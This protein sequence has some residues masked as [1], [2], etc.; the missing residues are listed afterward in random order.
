MKRVE[1]RVLILAPRG[2][3]AQVL[4]Q[5]AV[6]LGCEAKI[7]A[8]VTQLTAALNEGAGTALIT[9]EAL[10][11]THLKPLFD[12][13]REQPAWSDFPF[14]LLAARQLVPR[15]PSAQAIVHE[16]GNVVVLERPIA[17]ATI[18]SAIDSAL[19]AR[20]RQYQTRNHLHERERAEERLQLALEAGRLGAWE[21][22]LTSW[23][24][25]ASRVCKQN[26]GRDPAAEFTYED[27]LASI[28]PDD[29][30]QFL[31][32][33]RDAVAKGG[34]LKIEYRTVWPDGSH[35]WIQVRGQ[36][37][38]GSQ[39]EPRMIGVT[40]DVTES[41]QAETELRES[42]EALKQLNETLESRIAERTKDLAR[43]NDRLTKE[44]AERER[45]QAALVQAQKM[46]AIGQLTNGIAHDFNN[47]LTAIVGNLDMI[48]RR[49]EDARS[50]RL[51]SYA[52]EAAR[53]ASRL[54]GQL[55]AFSRSQRL[56]LRPVCVDRLIEE[57]NDL[58]R[59]SIGP[60]IDIKLDLA[61]GGTYAVAD[62]NQ[63]ELAILNL[64]INARDAMPDGGTLTIASTVREPDGV[65][66]KPGSYVV[67]SIT[68][69]GIGIPLHLQQ[70]V[71][72][73]FFTTKPTGKGTG[74]GLSQVYGIAQQSGG[75]A[76]LISTPGHGTTVELWLPLSTEATETTT[77][78]DT[79]GA[80]QSIAS[81][82]SILVIED[83]HDVRR[84]ICEYLNTLGFTVA[85][86]DNGQAGLEHL[87]RSQPDLLI[88]DFA[89]PGMNG[90]EVASFVRQRY[91]LLPIIFVTGYADMDA[92]ER[93]SGTKFVLRKPFD[94][95]ALSTIVRDAL[96]L[97][98]SPAK[99]Y[100]S[101]TSEAL[102]SHA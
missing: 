70:K 48:V 8:D 25:D 80:E 33:V 65:D 67:I 100:S 14:I 64:V 53:R 58:V 19:R 97:A 43:A 20:R 23:K 5:L 68:D 24:L 88:V 22:D 94:A 55:L 13:L 101:A 90:A 92:L 16:L 82:E 32:T 4:Y 15:T 45:A 84:F 85:E 11:G 40:L 98:S 76:R 30:A 21:L 47:L 99:A 39:G 71:F 62:A 50:R 18:A 74:L 41:R 77:S 3:D 61:C 37:I 35:H 17:A 51:A 72:E 29:R 1:E 63:L 56:D 54:T 10:Q 46:E 60:T 91:P 31:D 93:V 95:N 7:C 102:H 96:R 27:L 2:R 78:G 69:T 83:D 6:E 34:T 36:C 26:F 59:R 66:L 86:A 81:G 38:V 12:W 52:L 75:T 79:V 57:M 42:R 87:E 28:H 44:I 73:P 89:M 49:S 9:E